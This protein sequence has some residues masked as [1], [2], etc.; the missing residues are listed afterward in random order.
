MTN[1]RKQNWTYVRSSAA[2]MLRMWLGA[3]LFLGGG[4]FMFASL[5]PADS[6]YEQLFSGTFS[7]LF[8]PVFLWMALTLRL[9]FNEDRVSF[10]ALP[11]CRYPI[12]GQ[13]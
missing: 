4:I 10:K 7:I 6:L 11:F 8:G 3:I 9:K 1:V 13:T 12:S 5:D 2:F